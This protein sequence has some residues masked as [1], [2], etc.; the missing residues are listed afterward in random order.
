[1]AKDVTSSAENPGNPLAVGA[2]MQALPM[3]H[4]I[5]GPL[6]ATIQAQV[7]S[8]KMYADWIQDVGLDENRKAVTV[9]FEYTE[10]QMGSDGKVVSTKTR[11]MKVPLLA[12]L[13]HP[14][15]NIDKASID[16]EMTVET[17]ESENA[18]TSGEGGFDAKV[19][20][21]PF[22]VRIHGKVSHKT[23]QTRKTDTRSKYSFHV[24]MGYAG[25]TEAMNRIIEHMTD[26]SV[27]PAEKTV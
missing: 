22:S 14:A 13:H 1:M 10:D 8:S 11:H 5:A 18:M 9:D 20:W 3:D 4:M 27:R 2:V 21:G 23:E 15:I 7:R 25:P 16:F 26:A 17:S 6:L 24:E 12:L 19:G